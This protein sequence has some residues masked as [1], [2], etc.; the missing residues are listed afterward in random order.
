MFNDMRQRIAE[1]L[2]RGNKLEKAVPPA[3]AMPAMPLEF[4]I[5]AA[6]RITHDDSQPYRPWPAAPQQPAMPVEYQVPPPPAPLPP[7]NFSPQPMPAPQMPQMSPGDDLARSYGLPPGS[8]MNPPTNPQ[9]A[10]GEPTPLGAPFGAPPMP[11]PDSVAEALRRMQPG[12]VQDQGNYAQ[13]Q[14]WW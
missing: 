3:P 6:P 7:P 2:L 10:T 4:Q 5:P 14:K 1:Y 12:W 11:T 9:Q 8:V 13:Q